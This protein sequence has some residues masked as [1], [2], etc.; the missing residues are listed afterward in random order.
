MS[1]QDILKEVISLPIEERALIVDQVLKSLNPSEKET[2]KLW[3]KLAKVRLKEIREGKVSTI[4][5][6][7]VFEKI[8]KR[9]SS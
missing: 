7:I 1:T 8:E 5:G 9:F 2:E 6:S 3:I 4:P